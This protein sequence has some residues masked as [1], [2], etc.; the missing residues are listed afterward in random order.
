M[1]TSGNIIRRNRGKIAV[2]AALAGAV[3]VGPKAWNEFED[4]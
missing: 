2:V 3:A 4:W 1:E